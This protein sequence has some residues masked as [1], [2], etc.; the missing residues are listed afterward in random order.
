MTHLTES[1]STQLKR[2]SKKGKN[3][4][5]P[6]ILSFVMIESTPKSQDQEKENIYFFA[7]YAG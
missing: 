4:L 1:Q 5:T 6:K 7:I 3:D 2:C